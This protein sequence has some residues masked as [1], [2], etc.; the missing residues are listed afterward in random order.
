MRA[1]K[2]CRG[3]GQASVPWEI[4]VSG[5]TPYTIPRR[6]VLPLLSASLTLSIADVDQSIGLA[7]P[8]SFQEPYQR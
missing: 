4:R 8:K 5:G 7:A 2:L 3:E 1:L 6:V